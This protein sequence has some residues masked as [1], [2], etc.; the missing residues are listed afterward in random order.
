MSDRRELIFYTI[1]SY[2]NLAFAALMVA[3]IL[4]I[5]PFALSQPA[6]LFGVFVLTGVV[7]YS[8]SSFRFLQKGL[9][10]NYVFRKGFRDFI[11]VNAFVALFFLVQSFVG[12]FDMVLNKNI[13]N[14]L[15]EN[16]L[17]QTSD[18]A[19]KMSKAEL[20]IL[21]DNL[22]NTLFI[23]LWIFIIYNLCLLIHILFTFRFMKKNPQLFDNK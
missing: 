11:K 23:L 5:L 21:K 9:R 10:K 4:L 1:L 12:L 22:T 3:S 18:I 16:F 13:I 14:N 2:L 7:L 20:K 17:I 6:M 15:I 19:A 8:F